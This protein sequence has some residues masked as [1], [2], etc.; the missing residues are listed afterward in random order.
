MASAT[1][2]ILS[3][4]KVFDLPQAGTNRVTRTLNLAQVGLFS[5]HATGF[6]TRSDDLDSRRSVKA[7]GGGPGGGRG[8][9]TTAPHRTTVILDWSLTSPDGK[10]TLKPR[11]VLQEV[12]I[13]ADVLARNSRPRRLQHPDVDADAGDSGE[14]RLDHRDRVQRDDLDL[15]AASA[16]PPPMLDVQQVMT[17]DE[18]AHLRA[19]PSIASAT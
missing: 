2:V 4:N 19:L 1:N 9:G 16:S 17:D 15:P 11:S 14:C 7:G 12:V 5:F 8:G 3:P 18:Q 10:T 13:A 6:V